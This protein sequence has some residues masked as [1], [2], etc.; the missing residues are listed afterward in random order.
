MARASLLRLVLPGSV[1]PG[2]TSLYYL[3]QFPLGSL[4]ADCSFVE[5]SGEIKM[6]G[7]SGAPSPKGATFTGHWQAT[8]L[9]A[10]RWRIWLENSSN[11]PGS[12]TRIGAWTKRWQGY[13]AV[14]L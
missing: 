11:K 2:Y 4:K 3:K 14:M 5:E 10:A 12:G 13:G 6:A 8:R 9:L 7:R 1:P